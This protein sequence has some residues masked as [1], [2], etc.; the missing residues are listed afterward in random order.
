[1]LGGSSLMA[2]LATT[3][4]ARSRAFYEGVL[5]LRLVSDDPFALVYDVQGTELRIQKVERFEPQPHTALG[6]SVGSIEAVV[7]EIVAR[8]GRFERFSSLAQDEAGIWK[9]PSGARIAWL[10]DPDGNLLSFTEKPKN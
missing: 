5:G 7:R 10:K 3:D 8:G 4:A 9:A 6:W 2:F 1:M